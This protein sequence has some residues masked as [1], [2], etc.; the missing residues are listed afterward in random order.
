MAPAV[1]GRR[2]DATV[3]GPRRATI[4]A[5]PTGGRRCHRY[6]ALLKRRFRVHSSWCWSGSSNGTPRTG[7]TRAELQFKSHFK[8]EAKF[9]SEE[10]SQ[11]SPSFGGAPP[12]GGSLAK[13]LGVFSA[14][15]RLNQ[16]HGSAL[17]WH[18]GARAHVLEEDR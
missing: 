4:I 16:S 3:P 7:V 10:S 2:F 11:I 17:S 12:G 18:S 15:G 9:F 8:G 6:G 13:S 14:H 1:P 5:G